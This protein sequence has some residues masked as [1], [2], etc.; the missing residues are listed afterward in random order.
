MSI[1]K[2]PSAEIA[3]KGFVQTRTAENLQTTITYQSTEEK[4]H[5]M[6]GAT[7]GWEITKPYGD[8]GTLDKITIKQ[9][10]GPFWHADL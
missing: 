4:L 8:Y 10:A 5:A 2:T 1:A 3:Y 6:V 7:S 9:E